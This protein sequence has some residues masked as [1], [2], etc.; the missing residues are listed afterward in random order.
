MDLSSVT[1]ILRNHGLKVTPQRLAVYSTL[2][3]MENHP[4]V[5]M[6]YQKLQPDHPTM[7]LATVYKA[8]QVL[9]HVGL[10][11]QLNMGEDSFRYDAKTMQHSHVR[12]TK[13]NRVDDVLDVDDDLVMGSVAA[14]TA[15]RLTGRQMYFFGLCSN[16][17]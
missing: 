7:S 8:L 6:L 4:T 11:Q 15:Y 2:Y 12:C 1:E 5:E 16:C 14:K 10:V 9:V 13:C 3:D 17:Q